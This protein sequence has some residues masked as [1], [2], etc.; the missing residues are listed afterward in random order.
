[1]TGCE[2]CSVERTL[3]MYVP[4][5][6]GNV[7]ASCGS[8]GRRRRVTAVSFVFRGHSRCRH[9]TSRAGFCFAESPGSNWRC[10]G[11]QIGRV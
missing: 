4:T 6:T 5:T 9:S 11:H 3:G 2:T 8:R 7:F 1:M 10:S